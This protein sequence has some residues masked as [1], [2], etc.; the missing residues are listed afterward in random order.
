MNKSDLATQLRIRQNKMALKIPMS[1]L[2]NISDDD[3]ID[4]YAKC[5]FCGKSMVNEVDLIIA[6]LNCID[7]NHFIDMTFDND[8]FVNCK[9]L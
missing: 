2:I 5:S 3:M 9:S 8:H 1:D 7:A 6:I 4:C